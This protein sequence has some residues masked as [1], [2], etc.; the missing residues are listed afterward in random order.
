MYNSSKI[1]QL[2]NDSYTITPS[3]TKIF[4][5]LI[6]SQSTP[7]CVMIILSTVVKFNF[8][9]NKREH[10]LPCSDLLGNSIPFPC[11]TEPIG[12]RLHLLSNSIHST[13]LLLIT[14]VYNGT[15]STAIILSTI[16]EEWKDT[17]AGGK[18]LFSRYYGGFVANFHTYNDKKQEYNTVHLVKVFVLQLI[19]IIYPM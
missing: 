10:T 2:L 17:G 6:D 13:H 5:I 4:T 1:L 7:L 14:K 15:R 3:T 19:R 11:T 9:V 12:F 16:V 8:F 18:D